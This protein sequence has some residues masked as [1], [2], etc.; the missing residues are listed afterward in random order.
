LIKPLEN[1][2]RWLLYYENLRKKDKEMNKNTYTLLNKFE[3]CG[4]TMVTAIIK[5]KVVCVMPEKV[6]NRIIETE[7]KYENK[8]I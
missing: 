1:C 2:I 6:Y 8:K 3:C 5:G 7:R 4:I